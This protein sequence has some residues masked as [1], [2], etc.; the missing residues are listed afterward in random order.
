MDHPKFTVTAPGLEHVDPQ[1]YKTGTVEIPDFGE[2]EP[3]VYSFEGQI[4]ANGKAAA[5]VKQA[6]HHKRKSVRLIAF[7]LGLGLFLKLLSL[8]G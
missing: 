3:S 8:L 5:A 7:V 2:A 1:T 4:R 6:F